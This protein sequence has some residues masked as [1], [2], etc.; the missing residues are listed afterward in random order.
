MK[1]DV[2]ASFRGAHNV[3][4][5]RRPYADGRPVEFAEVYCTVQEGPKNM[6]GRAIRVQFTAAEARHTAAQLLKAA[7]IIEERA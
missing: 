3:P 7:A 1:Q 5:I 4:I 2:W 6:V